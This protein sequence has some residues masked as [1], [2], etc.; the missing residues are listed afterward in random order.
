MDRGFFPMSTGF[1][2]GVRGDP[3]RRNTTT[4]EDAYKVAKKPARADS[5]HVRY[6]HK[7][8]INPH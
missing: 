2:P 7:A 6:W 1:G 3:S 4:Q 8:D 5:L